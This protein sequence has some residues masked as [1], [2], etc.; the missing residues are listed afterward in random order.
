[1]T[2]L[3]HAT[4]REIGLNPERLDVAYRLL[5]EASS[6]D[7]RLFPGAAI[8]V[9]RHHRSVGPRFFG[10]Q[11]PEPDAEPIRQDGTFQLASIT[12]PVTYMAGMMMVE[13]GL[14]SLSDRV[15]RYIPEF[16]AH[17]K[18]DTLVVHLFTHTSGMPNMLP[19]NIELRARHA[20][21]AD[22]IRGAI[23]D[24]TPLFPPG[25]NLS[26][27]SMG[28]LVVAEIIQRLTGMSIHE[29]LKKEIFEPLGL[30]SSGLGSRDLPREKLVRVGLPESDL[31]KDYNW[32]SQYWQELGAPWGG[33][34]SS[35]EDL[36]V[37]CQLM[38]DGG[39]YGDVRLLSQR[40][41]EMM[42][43]NQLEFLP[44]LP[45]PVRRTQPWGLG[46]RLN[47]LSSDRPWSD[48]LGTEVYGHNGVTGTMVW[49]DPRRQGFCVLL[50]TYEDW[51]FL[52]RV[53]NAVASAFE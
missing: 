49:I 10:R 2:A 23:R 32:N 6:G 53:S 40:T 46:W 13:R 31:G 44:T 26:Y 16:A 42:T 48:L 21:L 4:P 1:M 14:L 29:F 17:H 38:L 20:P 18:E 15:V 45:E 7:A 37:L 22:F 41:V 39:V 43:V 27:Q 30:R 19:S 52:V 47:H 3:P 5:E 34:F 28:T 11:G 9:G 35:P 50:T 33:M 12:K 8:L 25:T 36:G 24:T 51:P